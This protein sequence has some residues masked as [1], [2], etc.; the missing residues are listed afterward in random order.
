MEEE[1]HTA[2]VSSPD[3]SIMMPKDD[4]D[5]D[6]RVMIYVGA[7]DLYQRVRHEKY[8][9][10]LYGDKIHYAVGSLVGQDEK[11]CYGTM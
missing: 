8:R 7:I 3:S 4:D 5:D 9:V 2:R 6:N 1:I 10:T 11:T